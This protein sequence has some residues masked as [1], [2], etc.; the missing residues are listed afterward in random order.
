MNKL[1]FLK[2]LGLLALLA[3]GLTQ[4]MTAAEPDAGSSKPLPRALLIG[5]SIRGGYGKGVQQLLAGKAEVLLNPGNAQYTG[6]GL[7]K[8]DEWLGDGKWDVIHFNWGLWDMYGWEYD[9][10][11]RSPA[12]YAERLE[13]LV[14]RM[15]KTGAKLIWATTTPACP[16]PEK[17]MR[18]RFKK[19]VQIT[20]EIQKKYQDAALQVM[21]KHHV[22]IDD[23]HA[24]LL[25]DLKKYQLGPDDVHFNEAGCERLV[26]QVSS[27]ILQQLPAQKAGLQTGADDPAKMSVKEM[28]EEFL[29]LK[30]GMFIHY[31]METYKGVQWVE[32][33]QNPADFNPGGRIDTDAWADAAK[34]AGMKYAVLTTKHVSGF[35]LWDSKYTTYDVMNPACPYQQDI[36]AQFIKSFTSRGIKVGLYYCWRNREYKSKFKVLPPEC[37]PA[38]HSFAEQVEFQKKQIAELVEKYPE[39]FCIWNDGLE[40]GIMPAGEANAF[41]RGLGRD[42]LAVANWWDWSKKGTPFLDI[43]VRE[44]KEFPED[45]TYPGET[46]WKLEQGWFWSEGASPETAPQIVDLLRRANSRRSNFLLNVGPDKQGRFEPASIKVLAEVGKSLEQNGTVR[47]N[48]PKEK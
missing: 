33:Y 11:D 38:S 42:V 19:Q 25:P 10:E 18:D 20:P 31:N 17:G 12:K 40:A 8:I 26:S 45:N 27:V 28:Q 34:S 41:Y 14:T 21:E 5:D 13:T 36:V 23:L 6:N 29:K 46:C 37:D 35:C 3:A 2:S 24:L 15:E 7:K 39:A 32:E 30:F 48:Q 44:T 4:R 47:E 9:K 16:E 43:A 22:A 1:K